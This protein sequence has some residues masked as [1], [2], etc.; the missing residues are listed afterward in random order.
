MLSAI[1]WAGGAGAET[2]ALT[3]FGGG[4]LKDLAQHALV[5]SSHD[6][7]PVEDSH[8][9]VAHMVA[10]GLKRRLHYEKQGTPAESTQVLKDERRQ[11]RRTR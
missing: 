2:V 8:M 11:H 7:M 9:V 10:D 3:G 4:G 6:Y 1:E 5:L